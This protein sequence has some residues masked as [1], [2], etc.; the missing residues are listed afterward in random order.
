M[1]N[2]KTNSIFAT[3]IPGL[4]SKSMLA[5]YKKN[6]EYLFSKGYTRKINVMDNQATEV[7]KAYLKP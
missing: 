6:F 5:A 4:D 1:Y 3:P 2:Y 7:I